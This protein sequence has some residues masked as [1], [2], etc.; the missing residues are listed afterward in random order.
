MLIFTIKKETIET[1]TVGTL[2]ALYFGTGIV[3]AYANSNEIIAAGISFGLAILMMAMLRTLHHGFRVERQF[4]VL[5]LLLVVIL[6]GFSASSVYHLKFDVG[7]FLY[8]LASCGAVY[9]IIVF[10]IGTLS[11]TLFVSAASIFFLYNLA[12]NTDLNEVLGFSQSSRNG[13]SIIM[14]NVT[15]LYY[16]MRLKAGKRVNFVPALIT[17][18]ISSWTLSRS[19]ILSSFLLLTGILY[20]SSRKLFI[21]LLIIAVGAFIFLIDINALLLSMTYFERLQ[22]LTDPDRQNMMRNYFDN[23]NAGT[24]LFGYYLR[25]TA[26]YNPHNSYIQ[27][28]SLIGAWAF[29]VIGIILTALWKALIR[30]RYYFV[31]L[32]TVLLRSATDTVMFF[33]IY[34]FILYYLVITIL[35]SDDTPEGIRSAYNSEEP[36]RGIATITTA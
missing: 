32:L 27:L 29:L 2:F 24:F 6:T 12:Q 30:N 19:G 15:V 1:A 17:F 34:D 26:M 33:D 25:N 14:I 7:F 10:P 11:T 20:L 9:A 22:D 21:S 35:A 4:A 18:I 5:L 23:I 16:M 8:I 31:L 36:A 13:I 28:H 3:G